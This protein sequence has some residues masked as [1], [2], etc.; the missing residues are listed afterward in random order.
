MYS[1]V[2]DL[3]KF[4][5]MLFAG[6]NAVLRPETLQSMWQPQLEL[7][8]KSR[9]S[10]SA[11]VWQIWM[12]MHWWDTGARSMDSPPSLEALP[13]DKV[14]VVVI[15][16]MDSANATSQNRQPR[17]RLMLASKQGAALPKFAE[18]QPVPLPLARAAA[19]P[20]RLGTETLDLLEENG[21]LFTLSS[22]GGSKLELRR[23]DEELLTDDRL[24]YGMKLQIFHDA[25]KTDAGIFQRAADPEPKPPPRDW[26]GLIGEYGWDY[27]T[28]YI[29]EKDGK[30]TSLIEWYE[31]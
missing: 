11:F 18:T 7:R 1:S 23:Q 21:K 26:D 14:G 2:L 5:S 22:N 12:A 19:S 17:A 24:S 10:A 25:V 20:Y 6:G 30:L 8:T 31:Y 29:L 4:V 3:S 27:D 13:S 9:I 15:T 16:T 28:L